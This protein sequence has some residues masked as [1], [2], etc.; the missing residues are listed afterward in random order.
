MDFMSLIWIFVLLMVLQPVLQKKVQEAMRQ[1]KIDE[2]QRKRGSRVIVLV[3]RQET[4][5]IL[6]IPLIRYIDVQ[7]SEQVLRVI[8]NTDDDT[9]IDFV[10]HTPGG[11][12][13]AAVQISRAL[14]KHKAD[15]RIL[16]P[17]YA[18]SGG[19]LLALAADQIVMNRHAVLGPVDPQLGQQPAASILA[20]VAKKPVKDLEDATLINAD[21]AQKAIVQVRTEA[22][23]LLASHM[24]AAQAKEVANKLASGV[25]THDYPI[26]AEEAQQMGLPVS[27]DMPIEVMD[28]MRLYPQP[29]NKQ[30]G[31][32]YLPRKHG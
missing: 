30:G 27:T 6:G 15:V 29:A 1:R 12:V 18:M 10:V 8:D 20:A 5:S 9:P 3:H 22:E 31:V 17:H 16:V 21:I 7:D 23:D 13:L 24:D 2:I 28:L 14:K 19:T 26:S 25:W 4:M 11:M 32:E